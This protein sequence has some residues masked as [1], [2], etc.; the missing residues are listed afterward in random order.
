MKN[1]KA[2]GREGGFGMVEIDWRVGER[3]SMQM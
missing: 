1:E 2:C 3:G